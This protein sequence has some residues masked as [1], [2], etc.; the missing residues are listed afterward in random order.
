[1][2]EFLF[3]YSRA[4][5][6]RGEILFASG[7]PVSLLFL[8]ITAAAV[9]VGFSLY[10]YR[11]DM[12][13][14]K[15]VVLG[16][17]QLA[18]IAILLGMLWRPALLTQ[19][20]R[21]NENAIALLIDT[22][23]SMRQS[24]DDETRLQEVV[25]T[26]E[27]G[28]LEDLEEQFPVELLGFAD[29]TVELPSLDVMPQPGNRTD[30]GQSLQ[31]VLSGASGGA[32]A[33]V[34]LITDG[35]DN[36]GNIDPAWF[37][38]IAG[39]GVPVHTLGIGREVLAEDIELEDVVLAPVSSPGSTVSAQVSIRH[40]RGA[41]ATLKVYDGDAILA[42]EVIRLPEQAGVTTRWVDFDIGDAG[43]RDLRFTI[44][45]VEGET[46]TV[47][48][49]QLRPVEVPQTRR[50][51]LYFE[52]EPRWEYKFMRRAIVDEDSPIRLATLLRTTPNKFY[53]QGL[54]SG[55]ELEEGF[56]ATEEELFSYDAIIIGS[57]EAAALTEEQQTMLKE[58]VSRRGGTLLMLG[59]ERGLADGGWGATPVGDV[60]PAYLPI[61]PEPSFYREPAKALLPEGSQSMITRLASDDA[62]N[63]AL[64]EEMP[65]LPH[66][67]TIAQDEL[68]P[69]AEV[70]LEAEFRGE[71][72]PLL[73]RHRYGEGWAYI[74]A[75]GTWRWQMLL[76]STDQRH[77]TFWRQLAQALTASAPQPVTLTS[78]RVYYGDQSEISFR[79]DVRDK[80]YQPAVGA[81]VSLVVDQPGGGREDY[82]MLPVPGMPGRYELTVDADLAGIYRFETNASLDG[83]PLGGA[84][85]AVRREDGV[86]ENFR[87][88]QNRALLERIAAATSGQYFTLANADEIP[89]AIQYSDAGIVERRLLEL[90]NMPALFLLLLLFKGG[91]WVLRLF[92]GRL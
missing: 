45:P 21:P 61:A 25:A 19:T 56:P 50:S 7:W 3:K 8:L 65:E 30:I 17:L 67:Q 59:A 64:W 79:A 46:N 44:D 75:G 22:S 91:E 72:W 28:L 5:F 4:T 27:D 41:E 70:L 73:F 47:N 34:V 76:E 40:G 92:W 48:N 24:D 71:T 66:F 29:R 62:E 85:L 2:F 68:K 6:E 58:F 60:L 31:S 15:T 16:V 87:I 84:R 23:A 86:S 78:E 38:R 54:S 49:T 37:A 12:S 11:N 83:E 77:E 90:W 57:L 43:V 10:R 35:A 33:A 82:D 52:G 89:E 81:T 53:R 74:L 36:A 69:G 88:Q 39:V 18:V 51:I 42:S 14:P 26:L 80:D 55:E 13:W 9:A 20:L 32:L 1:L 63:A